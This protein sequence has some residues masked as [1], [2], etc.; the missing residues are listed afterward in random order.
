[1]EKLVEQI[2]PEQEEAELDTEASELQVEDLDFWTLSF[3]KEHIDMPERIDFNP[4]KELEAIK[5][6]VAESPEEEQSNQRVLLMRNFKRRLKVLRE[7]MAKAQLEVEGFIRKNPKADKKELLRIVE[8][9]AN[10]NNVSAQVSYLQEAVRLYFQAHTNIIDT[11][12]IYKTRY[13]D[14]WQAELFKDLF[15][16]PPCGQIEIEEMPMHIYI[17]IGDIKD[18]V[19]AFGESENIARNSGGGSLVGKKFPKVEALS[20]KV[21]IENE[22]FSSLE[23]AEKVTKPHE[24]E[25]AIHK[26]IYP[27]SAFIKGEQGWLRGLGYN[28]EVELSLFNTAISKSITNIFLSNWLYIAKT[29]ILAYMKNGQT[30]GAIKQLLTDPHGLYNFLDNARERYQNWFLDHLKIAGTRVRGPN[31][32]HLT[33]EEIRIMYSD[34]LEEAW[35]K[36]YLPILEKTFQAIGKILD[37][38]GQDKYP[39][40]MRLLAQEPLNKWPRLA[41][42]LS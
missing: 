8:D 4:D 31:N 38:Y 24:E 3:L 1:M 9:I 15:G 18:Y 23:Y 10:R 40:I 32:R 21:L 19:V 7:N 2:P 16:Q 27:R 30:I 36:R 42:I 39:E 35:H 26:N 37:H 33:V 34:A 41:K 14:T 6:A 5:K 17:K 11:V 22:S 12:Q 25:H 13:P 20:Y 29:E 28:K